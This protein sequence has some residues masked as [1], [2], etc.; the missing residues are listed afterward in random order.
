MQ[1]G[2]VLA[3]A[4]VV[5]LLA[6]PVF[7]Y[8]KGR[9][10]VAQQAAMYCPDCGGGLACCVQCKEEVCECSP[11]DCK[12]HRDRKFYPPVADDF[13]RLEL[14]HSV[15]RILPPA[16]GRVFSVY[17]RTE[18]IRSVFS[19]AKQHYLDGKGMQCS[20]ES[21]PICGHYK[22]LW[23]SADQIENWQEREKI[24]REARQVKPVQRW[25]S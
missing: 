25:W 6:Y 2:T 24:T 19:S 22:E 8:A 7:V 11:C 13:L 5:G 16:P 23:K 15:I 20:G 9:K 1:T 21:C 14:G 12:P 17:R 4:F 10:E 18:E 3:V